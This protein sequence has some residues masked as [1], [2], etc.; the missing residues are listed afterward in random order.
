[1][2]DDNPHTPKPEHMLR[3]LGDQAG[4]KLAEKLF[5]T[6]IDQGRDD[7]SRFPEFCIAL[8]RLLGEFGGRRAVEE[9]GEGKP[10]R[11]PAR[12]DSYA[13]DE[14]LHASASVR[15]VKEAVTAALRSWTPK[16]R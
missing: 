14:D 13:D 12:D 6:Y 10:Q 11:L 4:R 9:E 2:S 16:R 8:D 1:M 3:I 5:D 7:Y 15:Q